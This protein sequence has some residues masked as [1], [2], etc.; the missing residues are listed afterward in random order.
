MVIRGDNIFVYPEIDSTNSK[1]RSLVL[2]GEA[3][4]GAVCVAYSQ[5]AG[6][7]RIKRCFFSPKG[8]GIYMSVFIRTKKDISEVVSMSSMAAV[9][10][11]RAIEET[12]GKAVEI[13]WI[14]D[15]Y[16]NGKKAAGILCET[17]SN[18]ETVRLSGVIIGVGVNCFEPEGGFPEEI[19]D[20]AIALGLR[21]EAE[22]ESLALALV[23]KLRE[24]GKYTENDWLSYYRAHSIVLGKNVVV[25]PNGTE[26]F[27]GIAEEIERNGALVVRAET[28]EYVTLNSGEIS[29]SLE[30]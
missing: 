22:M 4:D 3:G 27:K 12:T 5:T 20:K 15:V 30:K 13:K 9:A 26:S 17:V 11:C 8:L 10:V 1:L 7:G 6:R 29:L 18:P 21:D 2:N 23:I 14:N 24:T 16:Y 25:Y 19:R 28:G